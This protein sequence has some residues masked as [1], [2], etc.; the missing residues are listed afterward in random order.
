MKFTD[1]TTSDDLRIEFLT[2]VIKLDRAI[3][4][5]YDS[6]RKGGATNQILAVHT[7]KMLLKWLFNNGDL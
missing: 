2:S 3:E 1:S 6:G 7:K 4:E 5:R